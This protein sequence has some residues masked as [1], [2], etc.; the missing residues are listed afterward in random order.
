MSSIPDQPPSFGDGS[1]QS[2]LGYLRKLLANNLDSPIHGNPEPWAG[3]IEG[4]TDN[5]LSS[6]PA[7]GSVQWKTEAVQ[8]KAQLVHVALQI[9][10]KT[11]AQLDELLCGRESLAK[12]VFGR[13]LTLAWVLRQWGSIDAR[14]DGVME[15]SPSSLHELV[16]QTMLG[17]LRSLGAR[18]SAQSSDH[19]PTWK[20]L[21]FILLECCTAISG[22]LNLPF[23][24]F[25]V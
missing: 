6:F 3:L 19:K 18:N 21:R 14:K 24:V 1:P 4:L 8:E 11:L 15:L 22:G 25:R 9:V 20:T 7:V 10:Q 13:L 2:T 16:T 23:L 5:F 12:K 17:L